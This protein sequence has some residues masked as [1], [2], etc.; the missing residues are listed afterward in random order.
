MDTPVKSLQDLF[1]EGEKIIWNIM[2]NGASL[3]YQRDLI[4]KKTQFIV[5]L[6]QNRKELADKELLFKLKKNEEI[7]KLMENGIKK[8]PA[9]DEVKEMSRVEE[10][11]IIKTSIDMETMAE[12]VKNRT[13]HLRISEIDINKIWIGD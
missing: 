6:G 7:K 1:N 10:Y 5:M 8:T 3:N 2:T 4:Q 13:Y 9:E 11:E 12:I